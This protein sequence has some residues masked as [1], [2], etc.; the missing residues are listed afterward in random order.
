MKKFQQ[1]FVY[2]LLNPK[3]TKY[4]YFSVKQHKMQNKPEFFTQTF[5]IFKCFSNTVAAN[6]TH[7]IDQSS[8]D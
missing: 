7:M 4:S 3:T 2:I 5:F 8:R 1:K 6:S